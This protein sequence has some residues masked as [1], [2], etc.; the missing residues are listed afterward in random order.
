MELLAIKVQSCTDIITNSSS[1]IFTIYDKNGLETFKE[2]ISTLVG[3]DFDK[4]FTLHL[5]IRDNDDW[6]IDRYNESKS[7]GESFED[8]CFQYDQDNFEG[9]PCIMGFWV[10]ALDPKDEGKA[11]MINQLY[12]LFDSEERY[13]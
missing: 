8:W 10:E 7:E 1:E 3:E 11:K 2:I 4:V 5:D 9:S 13:C 6:L 12:T